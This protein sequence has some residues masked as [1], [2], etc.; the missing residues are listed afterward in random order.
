MR[1][2]QLVVPLPPHEAMRVPGHVASGHLVPNA[3]MTM[4]K[5][6]SNSPKKP[7]HYD[8]YTLACHASKQTNYSGENHVIA[9]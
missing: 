3:G 6:P 4:K 7:L 8:E 5:K 1:V 9:I 2:A